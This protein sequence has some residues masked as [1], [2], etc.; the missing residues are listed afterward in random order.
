MNPMN[1]LGGEHQ[2]VTRGK[3]TKSKKT[4][5]LFGVANAMCRERLFVLESP[6][7][8][9]DLLSVGE[10]ICLPQH[11]WAYGGVHKVNDVVAVMS[12]HFYMLEKPN[13]FY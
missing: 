9:P 11:S 5:F 4:C 1:H 7:F 8:L 10:N 13:R 12:F 6:T 2:N 3:S